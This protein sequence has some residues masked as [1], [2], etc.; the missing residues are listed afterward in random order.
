MAGKKKKKKRIW[1]YRFDIK[2][3]M[4]QIPAHV[5]VDQKVNSLQKQSEKTT[6]RKK[7][8]GNK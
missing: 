4:K 7:L 6:V 1:K 2:T 8:S 3:T 5:L